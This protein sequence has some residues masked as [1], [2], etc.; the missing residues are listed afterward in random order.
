[1]T[2]LKQYTTQIDGVINSHAI[3]AES[4]IIGVPSGLGSG[5]E[6]VKTYVRLKPWESVTPEEI[7]S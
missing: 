6:E 1:L 2:C 7:I 4:A 3:V 5:E